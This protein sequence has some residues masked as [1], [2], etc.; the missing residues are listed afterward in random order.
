MEKEELLAHDLG[1]WLV[2]THDDAPGGAEIE[3]EG[4]SVVAAEPRMRPTTSS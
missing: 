3:K 1:G 2:I 4:R